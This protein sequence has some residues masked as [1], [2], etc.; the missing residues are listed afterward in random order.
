MNKKEIKVP[1]EV[2]LIYDRER[3]EEMCGMGFINVADS[4]SNKDVVKKS[5][6]FLVLKIN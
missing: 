4:N 3:L 5:S 1:L 2:T 6:Y